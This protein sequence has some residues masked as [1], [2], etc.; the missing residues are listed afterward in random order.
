MAKGVTRGDVYLSTEVVLDIED[1]L[2]APCAVNLFNTITLSQERLVR[3]VA[4]LTDARMQ[5]VCIALA[6][7]LGCS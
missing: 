1:G 3:R 5:E 2:K 4:H 7:S 6:F